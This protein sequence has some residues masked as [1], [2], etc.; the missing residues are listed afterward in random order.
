[1]IYTDVGWRDFRLVQQARSVGVFNPKFK[2]KDGI[3]RS[4]YQEIIEA[5][6]RLS[7]VFVY[8]DPAHDPNKVY[9]QIFPGSATT[10]LGGAYGRI[11]RLSKPE[12]VLDRIE[13]V[14]LT[15]RGN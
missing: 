13:Q 14:A 12:F 7:S 5:A 9:E 11:E 4:V 10:G 6:T 15:L 3:S 2:S 8:Q 1:M